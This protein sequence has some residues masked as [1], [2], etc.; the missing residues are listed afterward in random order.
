MNYRIVKKPNGYIVEHKIV[1]WSIFGLKEEWNPFVKTSGMEEICWHHKTYS[2]AMM[3]LLDL[4]RLQTIENESYQ[5]K[6]SEKKER[7]EEFINKTELLRLLTAFV[8]LIQHENIFAKD[9]NIDSKAK[10]LIS[11]ATEAI[12]KKRVEYYL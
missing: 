6:S 8:I 5:V 10:E 2:Y 1:K 3:N 11:K 9:Q 4:V 7:Q 12:D